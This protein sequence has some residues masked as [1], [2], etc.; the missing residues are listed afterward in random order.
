MFSILKNQKH[1]TL[2]TCF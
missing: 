2:D 1:Q